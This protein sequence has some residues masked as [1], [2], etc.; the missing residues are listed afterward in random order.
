MRGSPGVGVGVILLPS[1]VGVG[2]FP[3]VL[4]ELF[5]FDWIFGENLDLIKESS[6]L[7][8]WDSSLSSNAFS[9]NKSFSSNSSNKSWSSLSFPSCTSECI[10]DCLAPKLFTFLFVFSEK[11]IK[12][13]GNFISYSS[14]TF[15]LICIFSFIPFSLFSSLLTLFFFSLSFSKF[16]SSKVSSKSGVSLSFLIFRKTL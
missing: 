4:S 11:S 3:G 14:S 13:W 15:S 9:I 6:L 1:G 5:I 12:N 7:E 2:V 16:A 10:E 8:I